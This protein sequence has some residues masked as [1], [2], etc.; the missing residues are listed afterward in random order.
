[1]MSGSGSLMDGSESMM[2]GYGSMMG[3]SE[4]MMSGSEPMMSGSGSM[5]SG[6]ESM[7]SGSGPMMSGSESMMEGHGSGTASGT[8]SG[9]ESGT[10]SGSGAGA[11]SSPSSCKCGIKR[12]KRILGGNET[13]I[14]E[15]PWMTAI[16]TPQGGQ[17]CGGTLI[18]SQWVLTASH[19]MFKDKD[20]TMPYTAAEIRAVLGDHHDDDDTE[21][22]LGEKSV[23][24]SKIIN[25]KDYDKVTLNI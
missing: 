8:A 20:Q 22:I 4:S 24:V 1:M 13:E 18:A 25:H 16:S 17:F 3:S 15:Y 2:S 11:T 23:E 9:S 6:S 14:N 7:M 5:M 10:S 21:S 12:T 19:C